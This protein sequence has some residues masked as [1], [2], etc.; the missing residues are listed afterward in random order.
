MT[1]GRPVRCAALVIAVAALTVLDGCTAASPYPGASGRPHATSGPDVSRL[2]DIGD[3]RMLYLEC[4]GSAAR[5]GTPTVVLLSG[6]GGAADEWMSV[7]DDASPQTPATSSPLSVFD[8]LARTEHVCAYDRPG[9]ISSAGAPSPSTIVHQPTTAQDGVDDLHALLA[10]AHQ[11]GPYVVVGASWGGLIA[12]LYAREHPEQ[13][14]GIV[15]V[16]SASAY[17]KQTLTPTQW[18]RWM[19]VIANAH[20][21]PDLESPDYDS[22]LTELAAAPVLPR[23]PATVL[24]SDQEWDLGVTPGR[25][26]WPAWLAAQDRLERSLGATH[27]G[28]TDSGHGIAVERPALVARAIEAIVRKTLTTR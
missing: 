25:S 19:S 26:T 14:R 15:L 3:G 11:P 5:A 1:M 23:I 21:N 24:S 18:S 17:L 10:A 27:I 6:T 8:T 28:K 16:D 20:T 4:R 9:T 2:V 7:A 13:T 22:S 12:Q